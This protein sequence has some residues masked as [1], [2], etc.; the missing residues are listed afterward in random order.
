[1][2]LITSVNHVA[3]ITDDLDR[4]IEFYTQVFE[5]DVV[6]TQ[7][8]PAFRH[9]I[10]RAGATSWLHPAEVSGNPHGAASPDMFQRGHLDHVAL[11]AADEASFAAAR[12][13]LVARE[14]SNGAV[15]DLGAFHSLWFH[16]PDGMRGEL[17]LIVDTGLNGIHEPR[18]LATGSAA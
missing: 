11:T 15:D 16:D 6:F 4:F 7:T 10:L 9:A 18:P 14:A 12:Q 13:R 2:S 1:M 17:T 3:V 5:L 8:T